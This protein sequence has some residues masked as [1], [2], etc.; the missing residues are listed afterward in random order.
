MVLP[1]QT[2]WERGFIRSEGMVAQWQSS[3]LSVFNKYC[4]P[5][6]QQVCYGHVFTIMW[7]CVCFI[8]HS[9]LLYIPPG[10]SKKLRLECWYLTGWPHSITR[11]GLKWNLK[12]EEIRKNFGGELCNFPGRSPFQQRSIVIKD[13]ILDIDLRRSSASLNI[14]LQHFTANDCMLDLG[15]FSFSSL[16]KRHPHPLHHQEI[17]LAAV[18][19]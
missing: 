16:P 19:Q 10:T 1:Q 9:A 14:C 18:W 4:I 7:L 11:Y 6:I 15:T 17:L 12:P 13:W 8:H 2:D 3:F 5:Q